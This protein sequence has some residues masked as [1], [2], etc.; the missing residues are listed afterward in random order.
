[1]NILG[2][3]VADHSRLARLLERAN[4]DGEALGEFARLL[5]EHVATAESLYA[6]LRTDE[7]ASA[8]IESARSAHA[9]LETTA[10]GVQT[11]GAGPTRTDRVAALQRM[12]AAHDHD[13]RSRL[14]PLA[15]D[16]LPASQLEN[17]FF[18][19]ER[20]RHLQSETHSLIFPATRFGFE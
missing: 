13:V 5:H 12:L 8:A 14:F 20:R 19:A 18:E 2:L 15:Q 16:A 7:A 9:E 4:E 6:L 17:A 3:L 1:M 10:T 11:G